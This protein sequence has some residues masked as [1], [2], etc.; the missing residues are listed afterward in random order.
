MSAAR[1]P[2][3]RRCPTCRREH[4]SWH[5]RE[6]GVCKRERMSGLPANR[7]WLREIQRDRQAERDRLTD[8]NAEHPQLEDSTPR[9]GKAI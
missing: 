4:R 2:P 3:L 6:C 7:G 1:L 5:D 8:L 9:K